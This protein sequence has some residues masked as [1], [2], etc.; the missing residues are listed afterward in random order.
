MTC[1]AF[2]WCAGQWLELSAAR[3]GA[4]ISRSLGAA[5]H[6]THQ[7]AGRAAA[8]A[9]LRLGCRHCR[10]GGGWIRRGRLLLWRDHP[11]ARVRSPGGGG[12]SRFGARR[13][14]LGSSARARWRCG[15]DRR[16]CRCGCCRGRR[17][18]GNRSRSRRWRLWFEHDGSSDDQRGQHDTAA[19]EQWC[20][21]LSAARGITAGLRRRRKTAAERRGDAQGRGDSER[22]RNAKADR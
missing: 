20:F 11:A 21:A 9:A 6:V 18:D 1:R 12:N 19:D 4:A 3:R 15:D 13:R 5:R 10:R 16:W 22:R 7:V 2:I 8:G 14:I 17:R